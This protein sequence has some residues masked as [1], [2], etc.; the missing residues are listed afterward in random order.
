M[1]N[2]KGLTLVELLIVVL[3][4][5]M[6]IAA[7]LECFSQIVYLT[8]VARNTSVAVSDVRDMI[9]EIAST[10]FDF[11]VGNFPD[12]DIDG[13]P[14]NDYSNVAGG[15]NLNNEHI[16]VNYVDEDSDPLEIMVTA[17]WTDIR[18]HHRSIQLS[19]FRTR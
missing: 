13:P 14:G 10:P 17:G 6:A 2:K 18:G 7:T 15:Y 16:V 19:T 11:I 1:T 8:E 12:G 9:E 5:C 3:V 4:V